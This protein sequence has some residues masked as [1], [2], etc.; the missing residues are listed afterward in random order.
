MSTGKELEGSVLEFLDGITGLGN[1]AVSRQQKVLAAGAQRMLAELREVYGKYERKGTGAYEAQQLY[2]RLRNLKELIPPKDAKALTEAFKG[3]LAKAYDKGSKTAKEMAEILKATPDTL[4]KTA[5]PNVPAINAAGIRLQDFWRKEN[6]NFRDRVTALTQTALAQGQGYRKLSLQIRELLVLERDSGRESERSQRLRKRMGVAGRAELIAR[7]EIQTAAINGK[8]NSFREMGY[9]W[10]RW[11]ATGERSCPFCI[12]R[13][14]LLYTLDDIDGAIPAHPRCRCSIIPADPPDDFKKKRFEDKGLDAAESLDDAYW[15]RSRAQKIREFQ[16]KNPKIGDGDLRRYARTPTNS[17]QFL[18]PGTPAPDWQWA[19]SGQLIPNLERSVLMAQ[20]AAE[21]AKAQD[22]AADEQKRLEQE[23]KA[24]EAKASAEAKKQE[25]ADKIIKEIQEQAAR[26]K[27]EQAAEALKAAQKA[28][29][30]PKVKERKN[31]EFSYK[32]HSNATGDEPDQNTIWTPKRQKLH[33]DIINKF[34]ST[35]KAI[36]KPTFVMSGGGPAS[37]KGFMLKKTG[38]D[39]PGKVVIDADEI[40]KL[41]P[42]YAKAQTK[43]GAA[44]QKAAGVVHEESSYLA[45]RIMA[46]ASK[47][48]FDVVLDGTGDN[49]IKS[50]NKKVQ[51]M[52][53]QG[54]RVEAKYVSADTDL[55]AQRNWDRFLK[56]GRLPPESM[57]RNVHADVSRTLPKAIEDG[58]FDSV[59]LFDTNVSGQLRKVVSQKN[60]G[61]LTIHDKQ[62]WDDFKRKGDVEQVTPEQGE[63][64]IEARALKIKENAKTSHEKHSNARG[65]GQEPDANTVWTMERQKL[66]REIVDKFLKEGVMSDKPVFTMSGGGP[67]SGKGFMIKK[68]GLDKSGNVI[69]DADEIKK[70]LPEYADAQK[71]GGKAQ[72]EAAGFVHEESSYL[73]KRIMAAASEKRFNVVLDGTGDNGIESLMKKVNKMKDKGYRVEAKYV[74]ADTDLAAQRNWDRFL[75]T[76]RLPPESMLRNVHADVSRTLPKAIEDGLFDKVELFD[77]NKSGELRKVISQKERG[78]PVIHDKKLWDDFKRKGEVEQVTPEQGEAMIA[79]R[80]A[81]HKARMEAEAKK[82]T[83]KAKAKTEKPKPNLEELDKQIIE[84]KAKAKAAA[85]EVR[86]YSSDYREAKRSKEYAEGY[87]ERNAEL[88]AGNEVITASIKQSKET[89][90]NADA[91]IKKYDSAKAMD[92]ERASMKAADDVLLA[93]LKRNGNI[94]MDPDDVAKLI[95]K[96]ADK[97]RNGEDIIKYSLPLDDVY[98]KQ[99][100]N[101]KPELV[102]TPQEFFE[103]ND[104][105][106]YGDGI[107]R[108]FFRG[109]GASKTGDDFLAQFQGKGDNGGKHFAGEGIFGNGTYAASSNTSSWKDIRYAFDEAETYTKG[110]GGGGTDS[111]MRMSPDRVGMFGVKKDAKVLKLSDFQQGDFT[112][113]QFVKSAQ[114]ILKTKATDPG[115][116]AAAMGYD[117]VMTQD[118]AGNYDQEFWIILNRGKVVSVDGSI[119]KNIP[120]DHRNDESGMPG[121][122]LT[123]KMSEQKLGKEIKTVDTKDRESVVGQWREGD[124]GT[125]ESS[126]LA[127]AMGLAPNAGRNEIMSWKARNLEKFKNIKDDMEA[128]YLKAKESDASG[129]EGEIFEALLTYMGNV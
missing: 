10:A 43:G 129:M 59:E 67:A 38:L 46:E 45:K 14:G 95:K 88:A 104:L 44:Q 13:D 48:R 105:L 79:K 54:Y 23:A 111:D 29:A 71:K 109:V 77:T 112:H 116:L 40:K 28:A 93:T 20:R 99:N 6:S 7:T 50:L 82:S 102:K 65:V 35:G 70:L 123:K 41:L 24:A 128:N 61:R 9:Q 64:M 19:P 119:A 106:M 60:G 75:K 72:Q 32:R 83:Q 58:I 53:D 15:T 17:Q 21:R 90:K 26:E 81:E 92:L 107:N 76:G 22:K 126:V 100:Y 80:T 74:S 56:T 57:L 115:E 5:K 101:T 3:D 34:L 125:H 94:M 68:T 33:D 12:S 49:G 4:K 11:S 110:V 114:R 31:E 36:A 62:L 124:Y 47:R 121:V 118:Q 86:K 91:V 8:L 87:I 117:V 85:A 16:S 103:R 108:P 27:A 52:R 55:A 96:K 127:N 37:G 25:E 97:D 39:K 1:P 84:S 2:A 51:K 89:I 63:R 30:K 73:A 69:I 113:S 98:K 18:K 42:E 122:E 66:H 120:R 78:R